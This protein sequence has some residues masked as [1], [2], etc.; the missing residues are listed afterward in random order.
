[1][2]ALS[3]ERLRR[4]LC[5]RF[6]DLLTNDDLDAIDLALLRT[7]A[8]HGTGDRDIRCLYDMT[9]I[10]AIAIPQSRFAERASKPAIGDLMR[11]VVAPP[12]AG[13]GFGES[14]RS[15]RCVWPHAQPII[16]GTLVEAYALLGIAIPRFEPLPTP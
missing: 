1:M 4:I 11:V 14:Y 13:D 7:A 3:F 10:R 2:L 9:E 15:A 8:E 16:V 5:L 6:T 12:W